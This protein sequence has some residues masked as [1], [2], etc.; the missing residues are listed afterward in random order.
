MIRPD[1]RLKTTTKENILSIISRYGPLTINQIK[2]YTNADSIVISAFLSELLSSKDIFIT[3]VSKG[4]GKFYYT[5]NQLPK[6]EALKEFLNDKDRATFEL[7]KREKVLMD[8]EQDLLTRVSLRKLKDF[9]VPLKV[10]LSEEDYEIFWSYFLLDKDSAMSLIKKKLN[11][12]FDSKQVSNKFISEQD[13]KHSNESNVIEDTKIKPTESILKYNNKNKKNKTQS[14]DKTQK[15]LNNSKNRIKDKP[16]SSFDRNKVIDKLNDL[17]GQDEMLKSILKYLEN[18]S[19]KIIELI[20]FKKSKEYV[21]HI[22]GKSF[23]DSYLNFCFIFKNK[24]RISSNDV[25]YNL[26]VAK[27]LNLIP[28]IACSGV[29]SK[30]AKKDILDNDKN[31]LFVENIEL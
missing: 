8:H 20:S 7:L 3:N 6:L 12:M 4:T 21:L 15:V 18:R 29:I 11:D 1:S 23:F 27:R 2:K 30:K 14:V 22:R 28:I 19:F 25:S 9:A 16:L 13:S 31:I 24:K 5:K 26:L 17:I 10:K